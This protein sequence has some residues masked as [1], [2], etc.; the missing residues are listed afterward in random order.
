MIR[1]IPYGMQTQSSNTGRL[2]IQVTSTLGLLPVSGARVRITSSENPNTVLEEITTDSIGRTGNI[3]LATPPLDYSLEPGSPKPY[4]N[5]DIS[6]TA[7]GFE[8]VTVEQ[9]ELLPDEVSIQPIR[10]LPTENNNSTEDIFIPPHTLYGDYPPKIPEEMVKPIAE[11]GE[12]VL[13]RVVIPEFVIVHDGVPSDSSAQNYY[14]NYL[15]YIKNVASSEIYA[16]W[17]EDTI[18][19][20]VLAIMSV[21]LNRV[22]TEFYRNQGYD[23]TITS[24]TAF[25]QKWIFGRNIFANISSIVDSIFNNY[26]SLPGVRQPIFAS[27][28]NG[29]TQV[30]DGLSQ[31]GSKYLGDEGY[32]PIQILRNYYGNSIYINS[33]DY[34]SGVPSSYPGYVLSQGSNGQSVYQ[35]QEQLNRIAQNYPLIPTLSVDGRYGPLTAEAVRVFQSI[36]GLPQTGT[37]DYATWYR[38]SQIYVGVT[39]IAEL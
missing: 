6:V 17:P 30:C 13:S 32:T 16:T 24:S 20:N 37:V 2:N 5:Y 4:A 27:Y 39:R 25:D 8:P 34:V 10:M 14:V 7:D 18:Y 29:T 19:A 12:I 33:T 31:W 21:T 26:L 35:L 38:I 36:F 9:S 22:F 23:F 3:S 11:T 28:C 15:D 1:Q